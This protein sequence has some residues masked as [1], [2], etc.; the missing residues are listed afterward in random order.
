MAPEAVPPP[1]GNGNHASRMTHAG[2]ALYVTLLTGRARPGEEDAVI[3]LHED[4]VRRRSLDGGLLSSE[5]LF[6]P[7]DPPAFLAISHFF[8]QAAA[9][10][11]WSDPEHSAWRGRL[12][13]LSESELAQHD[14]LSLWRASSLP[15]ATPTLRAP[16][17]RRDHAV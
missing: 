15:S 7:A 12:A 9:E 16:P 17:G 10:R 2:G 4:W 8:D 11:S 1:A 3:A 13:S 5:I 6:D 14:M